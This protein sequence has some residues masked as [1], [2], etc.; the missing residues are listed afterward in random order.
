MVN[1]LPAC[2]T[3]EERESKPDLDSW[4]A[5]SKTPRENT[6][7]GLNFSRPDLNRGRGEKKQKKTRFATGLGKFK[8][9]HAGQRIFDD[10]P[11]GGLF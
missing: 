1:L 2:A 4:P 11:R 10:V 5:E 3:V 7:L 8:S 6:D 9:A